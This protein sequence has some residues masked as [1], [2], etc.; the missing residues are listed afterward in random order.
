MEP[1]K[2]WT[3]KELLTHLLRQAKEHGYTD[4]ARLETAVYSEKWNPIEDF[5]GCNLVQDKYHPYLPCFIH[6]YS[7]IV[8]GGG[9]NTDKEFYDNLVMCGMSKFKARIMYLAVRIAWVY[10]KRKIKK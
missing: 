3:K 1:Y 7:W 8:D 4:E 2:F 10:L 9:R 6:D 5:N